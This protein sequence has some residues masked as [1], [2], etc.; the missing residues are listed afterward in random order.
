MGNLCGKESSDPFAGPGRQL[1]SSSPPASSGRATLPNSKKPKITGPGRTLSENT[2]AGGGAGD[3]ARR[4]AAQAAEERAQKAKQVKGKLGAQLAQQ[5]Q[6]TRTDTLGSMT[7][8]ELRRR[9]Q[10]ENAA[11]RDWS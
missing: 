6:Q 9:D 3:D 2:H 10:D 11:A 5:K 4:Q 1:G 8:E 7:A